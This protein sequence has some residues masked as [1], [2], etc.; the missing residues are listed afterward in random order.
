MMFQ[1][2]QQVEPAVAAIRRHWSGQPRAGLVF[3]SG[4]GDLAAG[5]DVEA[6]LD[7]ESI[8][9]F[10]RSS[11]P[12]HRGRWICGTLAGVPIVAMDGRAHAYEGCR[13]Q[14]VAFGVRV[15]HAL[16][17][18]TLILSNACGGLNPNFRAG[19]V[20]IVEDHVNLT[21]A[22]PLVGRHDGDSGVKYPDLSQPYDA[23]L[24]QTA[25]AVAR[26]HDIVVHRGVYIGVMGP[27]YETR[28]EVRML[29]ALGGD[30]VGMSTVFEVIVAAQCGL[31]VLALSVVTNVCLPDRRQATNERQVI[32]AAA[33]AAPN[34]GTIVRGVLSR[35]VT[36]RSG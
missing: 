10:P 4:L 19:E 23:R 12:G 33:D 7:Y 24:M 11:A 32:T 8:P 5:V 16:G 18:E 20:M 35:E 1:S 26:H 17:V 34:V 13:A 22:G 30:A 6:Q 15:M 2:I 9:H 27:N 28:A 25:L 14:D 36:A 3:G 21:F 29:R 31:R